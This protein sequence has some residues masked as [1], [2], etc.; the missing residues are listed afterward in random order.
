[1]RGWLVP[2][3]RRRR[4]PFRAKKMLTLAPVTR[5][6]TAALDRIVASPRRKM[7]GG[8]GTLDRNFCQNSGVP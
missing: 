2:G 3:A 1:M 6:G 5:L 7:R 8:F 4:P